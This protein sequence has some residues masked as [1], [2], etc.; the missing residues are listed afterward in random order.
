MAA[1]RRVRPAARPTLA[2]PSS[3]R[4]SRATYGPLTASRGH[5]HGKSRSNIQ[6]CPTLCLS[7]PSL[8]PGGTSGY[9]ELPPAASTTAPPNT[10]SHSQLGST[11]HYTRKTGPSIVP[12]GHQHWCRYSKAAAIGQPSPCAEQLNKLF[13]RVHCATIRQAEWLA[14]ALLV[15]QHR[16]PTAGYILPRQAGRHFCRQA[17]KLTASTLPKHTTLDSICTKV[18]PHLAIDSVAG[19]DAELQ[20]PAQAAIWLM[21]L[22]ITQTV[23]GRD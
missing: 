7:C 6:R 16:T 10:I 5:S 4:S 14:A 23:A 18:I 3:G 22:T 9:C 8:F 12:F 21:R 2:W 1:D 13:K 20:S 19:C 11:V 17:L 15:L